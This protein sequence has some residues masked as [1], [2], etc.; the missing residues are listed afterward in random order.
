M[1]GLLYKDF[2]M[3]CKQA[4][5]T[6]VAAALMMLCGGAFGNPSGAFLL[7][8]GGM[9]LGMTPN[10]L[11]SY[12]ER[13]GWQTY[14]KILPVS[15]KKIVGEKYLL[16]LIIIAAEFA[17]DALSIGLSALCGYVWPI[18]N[19]TTCLAIAAALSLLVCT[20][21][22]PLSYR[23]GTKKGNIILY[24]FMGAWTAVML[25]FGFDNPS[26]ANISAFTTPSLL[27]AAASA[28]LYALSWRLSA[29]WYGKAEEISR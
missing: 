15:S 12:E 19:V 24:I 25:M 2:C 23:F 11:L 6:L 22:L 29:A 5:T 26:Q 14:V 17:L 20:F 21:T 9:M 13:E 1:K 28:V 27:L 8:Y 10:T 3:L 18:K 16:G 7:L 4:K